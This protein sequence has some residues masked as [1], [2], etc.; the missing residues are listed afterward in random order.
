M[1]LLPWQNQ[2]CGFSAVWNRIHVH[3]L[4]NMV[5]KTYHG[6]WLLVL[7]PPLGR[8]DVIPL[9][10]LS[11]KANREDFHNCHNMKT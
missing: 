8:L 2:S 4:T 1:T 9:I 11:N 6:A 7:C 5:R 10:F 3:L